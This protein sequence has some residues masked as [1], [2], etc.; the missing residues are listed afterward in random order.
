MLQ[1][2]RTDLLDETEEMV[3]H[4][5]EKDKEKLKESSG[6][7]FREKRKGRFIVTEIRVDENGAE[8]IGRKSGTYI[9]LTA[10]GLT[11]DDSEGFVELEQLLA[12]K[13]REMHTPLGLPENPKVLVVGLGNRSV[14]PDAVGPYAIDRLQDAVPAFYSEDPGLIAYAAGVTGQTGFETS[15]FVNALATKIS[16][17]LIIVIDALAARDSKRLCRTIQLTD[18]G[19]HPGSG[20]GNERKEISKEVLGIPVTAIGVPTVVDGPVMVSDAIESVFNYIAAKIEEKNAPSSALAVTPW[21]HDKTKETDKT[22]LK[23]IFGEWSQ[24]SKEDKQKLFEEVLSSDEQSMFVTPKETDTW[25]LQYATLVS[26]GVVK[27]L[28]PAAPG[29]ESPASA[30]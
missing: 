5:T 11:A 29:S 3:R 24:W 8:K 20:V 27:W 17:D 18:T 2:G 23:P 21:L 10:P 1:F 13:L 25:I 6:I 16:P 7:D 12:D 19:I 22:V 30:I 15:D 9:T 14:T 28:S 26:A 4:R